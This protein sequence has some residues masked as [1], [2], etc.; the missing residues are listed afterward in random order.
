MKDIKHKELM[1]DIDNVGGTD[2]VSY[3][4]D[5]YGKSSLEHERK[6]HELMTAYTESISKQEWN[7]AIDA[8]M[9]FMD[10]NGIMCYHLCLLKKI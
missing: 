9:D 7:N 10:A 1:D 8:V 2:V 6:S 3:I 5:P 4:L